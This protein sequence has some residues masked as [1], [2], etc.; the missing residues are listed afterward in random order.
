MSYPQYPGG[1]QPYGPAPSPV[2]TSGTAITAGVL[3][4]IGAV[5]QFF[6]GG[7]LIAFAFTSFGLDFSEYDSSGLIGQS[8][9]TT[10]AGISGGFEVLAAILL[11]V[12]AITLFNRKVF[13]R[14]LVVVGCGLVVLIGIVGF[15]VEL[16][17]GTGG[18]TIGGG[19]GGVISLI[20]PVVTAI[21]ALVPATSRWLHHDPASAYAPPVAR[22]PYGPAT[23]SPAPY[24]PGVG[25]PAAYPQAV[26]DWQP[27]AG[28]AYPGA[29][30]AYP[31]PAPPV[32]PQA[33]SG[34]PDP[35]YP[36]PDLAQRQADPT[37][38]ADDNPWRRPPSQ[39]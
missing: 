31:P 4:C 14:A 36:Q 10:F 18:A 21:L 38:K 33:D 6:S 16:D 2:P 23:Y 9:Y 5:G 11:A 15:V 35:G 12:G 32:Y 25:Q 1:Y 26:P 39:Q 7:I 28:T 29:G 20:F 24:Q 37:V 3:A 22:Y 19:I 27:Q 17:Y 13:G 34:Y 8:W 30:S